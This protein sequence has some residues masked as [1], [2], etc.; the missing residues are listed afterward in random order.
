MG[1]SKTYH[2][3]PR[4]FFA[5]HWWVATLCL[6]KAALY[7]FSK[8]DLL[9]EVSRFS[10]IFSVDEYNTWHLHIVSFTK[11]NLNTSKA[12]KC[13]RRNYCKTSHVFTPTFLTLWFLNLRQE[14]AFFL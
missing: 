9:L 8:I 14:T 1:N 13:T 7:T 2:D 11:L 10:L 4:F 6:E 12:P 3:P 5:P